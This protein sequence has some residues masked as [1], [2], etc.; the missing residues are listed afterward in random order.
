MKRISL[1]ILLAAG[2]IALA[3]VAGTPVYAQDVVTLGQ[4][5]AA[6]GDAAKVPVW[7]LDTGGTV[8]GIGQ[9]AGQRIQG[10]SFK[11]SYFPPEAI[12]SATFSRAGIT[13]SLKPI[14]EASPAS[15]NTAGY[16]VSFDEKTNPIPFTV[17]QSK[18]NPGD[19]VAVLT[20]K[21]SPEA[22]PGTV[23][24]LTLDP[25]VTILTNQGGTITETTEAGN[26]ILVNGS[27]TVTD[28]KP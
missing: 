12:V 10:L 1:L 2:L 15:G 3:L 22:F 5:R 8:L 7:V 20:L 28:K 23:V 26:L 19:W 4:I 6:P 11:V 18:T 16:L 9:T 27:L 24:T 13:S 14:F 25:G 17:S 21:I